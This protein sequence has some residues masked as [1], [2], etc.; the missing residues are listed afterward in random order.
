M[1]KVHGKLKIRVLYNG[2]LVDEAVFDRKKV[3]IGRDPACDL[4]IDNSG[5]E[6]ETRRQVEKLWKKLEKLRQERK[7]SSV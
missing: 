1:W 6:K 2:K 3:T 7:G 4:V 5:S